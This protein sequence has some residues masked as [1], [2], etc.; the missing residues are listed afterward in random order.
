M[1]V[2]AVVV[3][4]GNAVVEDLSLRR[5][6]RRD[7]PVRHHGHDH[8]RQHELCQG[9]SLDVDVVLRVLVCECEVEVEVVVDL[10][11]SVLVMSTWR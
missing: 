9:G 4:A 3:V 5:W 1:L 10:V 2:G 7:V 8:H 6:S 11:E